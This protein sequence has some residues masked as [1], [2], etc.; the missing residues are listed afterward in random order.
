MPTALT[1]ALDRVKREPESATAQ[2]R[3][4]NVLLEPIVKQ[5]L[6]V[7]MEEDKSFATVGPQNAIHYELADETIGHTRGST[8]YDHV[9]RVLIGTDLLK[10]EIH[11][12]FSLTEYGRHFAEWLIDNNQKADYFSAQ[13]M[14][15]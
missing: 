5:I 2:F 11:Q 4:F 8:S 15:N 10:Q 6:I 12:V 7:M 3:A 1:E 9:Q 13:N 14:A